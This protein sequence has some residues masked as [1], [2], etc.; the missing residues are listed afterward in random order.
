MRAHQQQRQHGRSGSD[1]MLD[2][3]GPPQAGGE[4]RRCKHESDIEGQPVAPVEIEIRL[5]TDRKD[6]E[7]QVQQ[8]ECAR[9]G[10]EAVRTEEQTSELHS[11]MRIP[12]AV[13]CLKKKKKNN[14]NHTTTNNQKHT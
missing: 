10:G 1:V 11:L 7:A 13:F 4:G 8:G 14:Q 5:N 2:A 6:Q 3:M 9:Y 12:Y